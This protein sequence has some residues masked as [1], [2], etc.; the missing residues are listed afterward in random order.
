MCQRWTS[1]W[2]STSVDGNKLKTV[3]LT[4]RVTS[5]RSPECLLLSHSPAPVDE[6]HWLHRQRRGNDV[7]GVV[8]PP[9]HHDESVHLAGDEDEAAGADEAQQ[10][11]PHKGV[12]A[13]QPPA[14]AHRVHLQ[15]H[16][17]VQLQGRHGNWPALEPH[18]GAKISYF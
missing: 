5:K 8:P 12:L 15:T 16:T 3:R 18:D 4:L 10:A 6:F 9:A 11:G 17:G 14:G 7:V 13:D 2:F 1:G